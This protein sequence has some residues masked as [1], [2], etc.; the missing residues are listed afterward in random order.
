M[1]HTDFSLLKKCPEKANQSCKSAEGFWIKLTMGIYILPQVVFSWSFY[2]FST[3]QQE[4]YLNKSYDSE[5]QVVGY[6]LIRMQCLALA[7]KWDSANMC[8]VE[9][10]VCENLNWKALMM[11]VRVRQLCCYSIFNQEIGLCFCT[12]EQRFFVCVFVCLFFL[13]YMCFSHV[14]QL[15]K[16]DFL[17]MINMM[18]GIDNIK[19]LKSAQP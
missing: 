16:C 15:Q 17:M 13:W 1:L 2:I 3:A 6:M 18:V 4:V 9:K 19:C 8:D 7:C 14:L 11:M 10:I 5:H 12:R